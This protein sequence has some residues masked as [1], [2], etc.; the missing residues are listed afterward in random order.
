MQMQRTFLTAFALLAAAVAAAESPLADAFPPAR[1]PDEPALL[2]RRLDSTRQ[3]PPSDLPNTGFEAIEPSGQ[4]S[5][6]LLN[7]YPEI[8]SEPD[9]P[10]TNHYA[11]VNRYSYY[12]QVFSYPVPAW[13]TFTVAARVRAEFGA[14]RP[15][16]YWEGTNSVTGE[17]RF[18][19]NP[20][21]SGA[22]T[23]WGPMY[24]SYT[25]Q[26]G[27]QTY[28]F[29]INTQADVSWADFDDLLLVTEEITNGGFEDDESGLDPRARWTLTGDA[30]ITATG[31]LTGTL[32]MHLSDGDRAEEL[33]A[34]T[35][36]VVRYFLAGRASGPFLLEE[37]RLLSSGEPATSSFS[38]QVTPGLDQRFFVDPLPADDEARAAVVAL[39]GTPAGPVVVD[40]ITRGWAYAWPPSLAPVAN[41]PRPTMRLAAAWPGN[42]DTAEIVL[43]DDEDV[44]QARLT[45]LQ[46]DG[47]SA[48]VDY[49]GGVLPAG[50]YTARFELTGLDGATIAPERTFTIDRGPGFP[51]RLDNFPTEGF[52]RMP[53]IWLYPFTEEGELTSVEQVEG[54]L[55]PAKEDGFNFLWIAAREDQYPLIKEAAT[56]V[57]LPY[58]IA[59][60]DLWPLFRSVQGNRTWDPQIVLAQL[61]QF[62]V[63][64]DSPL[65]AGIYLYDEPNVGGAAFTRRVMSASLEMQRDGEYPP[66]VVFLS[67]G[68][69]LQ[70]ADFPFFCT[71]SYPFTHSVLPPAESLLDEATMVEGH[72]LQATAQGRDYWLGT[73]GY[74]MHQFSDVM[75]PAECSAQLGMGLA[76]GMRGYFTFLYTT[77]G[78]LAGLRTQQYAE[79]ARLDA[80]RDF[81]ARTAAIES[82][83][84]TLPQ[85]RTTPPQTNVF[86]RTCLHPEG[87][88]YAVVVNHHV[89]DL[90]TLTV[91]TDAETRMVNA[92]S[93]AKT[94]EGT[95][96]EVVMAPGQW[97]VYTFEDD[98]APTNFVGQ[99]QSVRPVGA[100]PVAV[101]TSF[102]TP[103]SAAIH[104]PPAR[105]RRCRLR[106]G[107]SPRGPL[108]GARQRGHRPPR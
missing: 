100:A 73:Q 107:E 7:G 57:G 62:D 53:W 44:E 36:D 83:L 85:E 46:Q 65:F 29:L 89:D 106:R 11:R 64:Q 35:P 43:L 13:Q 71:Y 47:S 72:I 98:A 28:G 54:M 6:W 101:I 31:A 99:L 74:A 23:A 4:P 42:L 84:L 76:L 56:Q 78:P 91:T 55:L 38:A 21:D 34:Y 27:D 88:T 8:R 92:E 95:L 87:G 90:L 58:L 94:P 18:L 63:F 67:P 68:A 104:R 80:Y 14:E 52:V 50:V 60:V 102:T 48:W 3:A 39:A 108:A 26:A 20:R 97:A 75:R 1:R 79:T 41:S 2:V 96:H 105:R 59:P 30:E 82:L 16:L 37:K 70:D 19:N 81:N 25:R 5:G 12:A 22:P 103:R 33:V 24:G 10:G 40:D 61:N 17:F 32:S 45:T 15:Q 9:G 51:A 49:D 69:T 86:A 93:G 66:G 77:T